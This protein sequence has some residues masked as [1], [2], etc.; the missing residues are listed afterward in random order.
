MA[1]AR[2]RFLYLLRASLRDETLVKLTL[3]KHRGAD[4]TLRNLFVRPVT[5]KAGPRLTFVWRHVTRD[6]TKNHTP[7]EALA[8]I[9]PLIGGDFLGRAWRVFPKRQVRIRAIRGVTLGHDFIDDGA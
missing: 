3:G 1:S 4:P 2:D 9:E 6:I 8:L 5:L 7:A